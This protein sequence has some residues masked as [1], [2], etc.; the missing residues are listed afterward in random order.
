MLRPG[1]VSVE[2]IEALIGPVKGNRGPTE[3]GTVPKAPGMKYRHYAPEAPAKLVAPEDLNKLLMD[4]RMSMKHLQEPLG[5]LLSDESLA[6]LEIIEPSWLTQS[7]GSREKPE[8]AAQ[9]LYGALRAFDEA[10]VSRIFIES[11]EPEGIGL[12]VMNRL[13]KVAA[14]EE[15]GLG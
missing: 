10:G 13:Q 15:E 7:L 12:A 14:A 1:G 9:R 4:L 3:E 8:E 11:Y 6:E 2:E 5:F